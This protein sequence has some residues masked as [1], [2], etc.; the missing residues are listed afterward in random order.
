MKVLICLIILNNLLW[1]IFCLKVNKTLNGSLNKIDYVT[2]I[3]NF[4]FTPISM[5]LAIKRIKKDFKN[6][7]DDP[8]SIRDVFSK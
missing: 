7:K 2:N 4:I 3:L 6:Y 1:Y 5:I 8:N